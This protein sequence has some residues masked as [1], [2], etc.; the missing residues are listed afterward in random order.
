MPTATQI[1][2]MHLMSL[3]A[4]QEKVGLEPAFNHVGRAPF[5]GQQRVESQMPPKIIMQELRAP[6]YFPLAQDLERFAIQHENTPRAVAIGCSKRANVYA[7]RST[8]DRVRTRIVS[9]RKNFFRFDHFDDLRF[10]R[11]GLGVDD[12]NMRGA[13]SRHNQVTALDVWMRRVRAK[14][15]TACIP[16]EMMKLIAKLRHPDLAYLPTVSARVWINVDYQKSVVELA[17]RAD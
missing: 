12:V 1:P 5:A 13:N 11:I 7:F 2:D 15:R 10:S 6:I 8:V 3:L 16:A 4:A 17:F 14:R 9:A